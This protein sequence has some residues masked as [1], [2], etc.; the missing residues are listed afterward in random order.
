MDV[1]AGRS[2][3]LTDL[4]REPEPGPSKIHLNEELHI[5][6]EENLASNSDESDQVVEANNALPPNFKTVINF[7][8][9]LTE[10]A[11]PPPSSPLSST[12][13]MR[14]IF[15]FNFLRLIILV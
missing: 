5:N 14:T 1:S 8:E 9:E 15:E 7:K 10:L 2:V 3:F 13:L 6:P 4:V 12:H 11:A